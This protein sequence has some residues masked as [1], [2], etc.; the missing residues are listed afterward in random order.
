MRVSPLVATSTTPRASRLRLRRTDAF[1]LLLLPDRYQVLQDSAGQAWVVPDPLII[2]HT[3][4]VNGVT[5]SRVRTEHGVVKVGDPST[6]LAVWRDHHGAIEVP[7]DYPVTAHGEDHPSWLSAYRVPSGVH[8]C[9]AWEK[10]IASAAGTRVDRDED[11]K[12]RFLAAVGRSFLGTP[13][14]HVLGVLRADLER[15]VMRARTRMDRS[16]SHRS[17]HARGTSKLRAMGWVDGVPANRGDIETAPVL[18]SQ[19]PPVA[20]AYLAGLSD[21][22]LRA[23]LEARTTE[24]AAEPPKRRRRSRKTAP[25]VADGGGDAVD[26]APAGLGPTTKLG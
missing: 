8:H 3:P 16:P 24:P 25:V 22:Q 23:L 21:A 2:P 19:A 18:P 7:R 10:P 13:G 26:S 11:A 15:E 12:I 4:G 14:D 9:W 20:E 6:V 1:S 17:I 5:E